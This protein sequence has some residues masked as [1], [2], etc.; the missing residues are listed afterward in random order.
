MERVLPRAAPPNLVSSIAGRTAFRR[1]TATN[2]TAS[3]APREINKK[4]GLSRLRR[5]SL[6]ACGQRVSRLHD[7]RAASSI[8]VNNLH[9]FSF[10]TRIASQD[11]KSKRLLLGRS[12]SLEGLCH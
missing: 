2:E 3:K 4:N 11:V 10:G 9:E 12:G 6:P 5:N 8:D 7:K 1:Y